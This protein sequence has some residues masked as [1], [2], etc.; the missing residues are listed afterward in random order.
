MPPPERAFLFI[1][2]NNWFHYLASARV[3][4]RLGLDYAKIANKLVGARVWAGTRYY[5]GRIDQS[6]QPRLYADQ[7][8][9]LASL[10][11]TDAR[12]ATRLGRIERRFETS[13]AA[14]ELKAFL[15]ALPQK[16][17]P[18]VF[19]GL[20]AIAKKH[21]KTAYY[22]EKAV[23]VLLAVEMLELAVA[24][25]YDVAYLLSADGDFTGAVS[26]VRRMGKKVFVAVPHPYNG[27][28]LAAVANTMIRLDANWFRDTYK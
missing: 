18:A 6:S 5:I 19:H 14:H 20:M 12:I 27:A 3:S 7:R 17:D 1:D 4:D 10:E 13:D 22:V 25:E 2:G 21:E 16:I 9:F 24:D 28:Q 8:K 15:N 26:A 23:D 11:N